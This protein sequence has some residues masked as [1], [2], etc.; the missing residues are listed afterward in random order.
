[1]VEEETLV[2]DKKRLIIIISLCV[3]VLGLSIAYALAASSLGDDTSGAT[4]KPTE[5]ADGDKL[6]TSGRPFMYPNIERAD[7]QDITITNE[8]GTFKAYRIEKSFYFEGAELLAYDK[9]KFS[10]LVVNAT[11]TL[12]TRKI[13]FD[14]P[15]DYKYE[16][17]GL[18]EETC[19][20]II[21]VNTIDKK[22]HKIIIGNKLAN[23]G[24]YYAKY[25]TKDFIYVLD[26][27]LE[28]S[29]LQSIYD[30]ITPMLVYPLESLKYSQI[31]NFYYSRE[32]T[33]FIAIR[34]A[35]LD[36]QETSKQPY[37][38]EFPKD[39]NYIASTYYY[40]EVLTSL[41]QL[42][43][44]KLCEYGI[45]PPGDEPVLE[46]RK[47]GETDEEYNKRVEEFPKKHARWVEDKA[48]YEEVLKKY[49]LD[50]PEHTILYTITPEEDPDAAAPYYLDC[51]ALN[52]DGVYYVY[53][54]YMGIIAEVPYDTLYWLE[55]DFNRFV[56]YAMF[57][58]NINDVKKITTTFDGVDY[59]FDL[60]HDGEGKANQVFYNGK[61]YNMDAFRQYYVTLLEFRIYGQTEKP[62]NGYPPVL[63][64]KI[65]TKSGDYEY[66]LY[67][68]STRKV[69][70]EVNGVGEFYVNVDKLL[71][72]KRETIMI[73][74]G[75][76]VK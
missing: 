50:N 12:A 61:E 25:S 56:E 57:S 18:T 27:T 68:A 72:F 14:N 16:D 75:E 23:G 31:T 9:E 39:K 13:K 55:W 7:V 41:T 54:M 65:E 38:V 21:E 62:T 24:G 32:G 74:K 22:Y 37:V 26:T 17:F 66:V 67:T 45:V 73:S 11:Y 64:I 71:Q 52:D 51:T 28:D 60:R 40:G 69:Y 44:S 48:K 43:G 29:V 6:G 8:H 30:F 33:P 53:S 70:F 10:S 1:M 36:E 42:T 5:D 34:N 35:T 47:E 20:A 76:L 59:V 3:L 4:S 15:E 19:K 63:K 46:D 58:M 2:M 49:G